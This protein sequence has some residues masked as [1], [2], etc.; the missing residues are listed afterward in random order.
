MFYPQFIANDVANSMRICRALSAA[1]A[2]GRL[3]SENL[4]DFDFLYAVFVCWITMESQTHRKMRKA[5]FAESTGRVLLE[6]MAFERA[7]CP[8]PTIR[9]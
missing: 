3:R 6:E 9:Q 1:V 5:N 8:L 7:M 4:V 2:V